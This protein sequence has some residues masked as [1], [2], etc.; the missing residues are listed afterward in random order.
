MNSEAIENLQS[1]SDFCRFC[2]NL[3]ELPEVSEIVECNRCGF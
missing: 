3:I 1:A 2:G